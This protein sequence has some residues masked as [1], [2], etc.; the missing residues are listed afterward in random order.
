MDVRICSTSIDCACSRRPSL[1]LR[2]LM[3][4]SLY[5]SQDFGSCLALLLYCPL[6]L[7]HSDAIFTR[8]FKTDCIISNLACCHRFSS[9][10]I[11]AIHMKGKPVKLPWLCCADSFILRS[12]SFKC[13]LRTF[14]WDLNLSN[15]KP[16]NCWF[17]TLIFKILVVAFAFCRNQ[18]SSELIKRLLQFCKITTIKGSESHATAAWLLPLPHHKVSCK[19]NQM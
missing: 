10:V 14:C 17:L 16:T 11:T 6:W 9:S 5:F 13:K 4:A 15:A 19:T 2:L 3:V 1:Y 12:A 18:W 7:L 8:F